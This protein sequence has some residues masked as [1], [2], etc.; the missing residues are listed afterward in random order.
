MRKKA[1]LLVGL[2]G[3]VA[4]LSLGVPTKAQADVGI[5]IG[6]PLPGI[7][8]YAGPPVYYAPRYYA[9]PPA[10]YGPSYYGGPVYYGGGYY[11][12]GYYGRGWGHGGYGHRHSRHCRH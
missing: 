2:V 1:L 3:V 7:S 10:Y 4:L 8:F 6:I 9:Y 12:R 5:S 11:R